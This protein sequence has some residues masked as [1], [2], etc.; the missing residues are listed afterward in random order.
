MRLLLVE[1]D[2]SLGSTLESRLKKEGYDVIWA[3]SVAQAQSL[4]ISQRSQ[5]AVMDVGLPDGTGFELAQ[6]IKTQSNCSLIF[7]TAMNSAENR[8]EGYELG[9][10]EFI[11]KPFHLKELL[12]RLKHVVENH[13]P[14]MIYRISGVEIHL[15]ASY[16]LQNEGQQAS[17]THR[18][19]KVLELLLRRSPAVVTRDEILD[20]LVGE[21]Q[22]PSHRTVDNVVVKL[23]QLLGAHAAQHL[24]SVRGAGYQWV[25]T[26]KT[27][28][29]NE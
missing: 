25:Q 24:Q 9:A 2:E 16:I 6:W 15:D 12:L 29:E 22:F 14:E 5:V 19:K 1:D 23:R 27:G 8:L 4:F 28:E 3:K 10:E 11:P 21:D 26:L 17:L 7:M 18:E 13:P 20:V